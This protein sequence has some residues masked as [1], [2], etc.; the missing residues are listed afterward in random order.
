M[1]NPVSL[2]ICIVAINVRGIKSNIDYIHYLISH[3]THP[4]IMCISEHWLHSY[5]LSYLFSAVPE[6]KG[7]VEALRRN[8][9]LHLDW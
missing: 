7:V 5:D 6:L 4:L 9:V 1:I 3:Y 8:I 2:L